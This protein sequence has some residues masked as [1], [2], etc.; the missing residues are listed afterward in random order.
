MYVEVSVN[1]ARE[2][3]RTMHMPTACWDQDL[4]ICVSQYVQQHLLFH[5]AHANSTGYLSSVIA[6]DVKSA[7]SSESFSMAR[8]E[9]S[10]GNLL[11]TSA[12]GACESS[13]YAQR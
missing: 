4:K 7:S 13:S 2:V 10:L 1:D 5:P 3:Y 8:A 6:I 11:E 12:D 9:T